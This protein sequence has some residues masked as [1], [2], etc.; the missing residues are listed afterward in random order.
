[1][2]TTKLLNF[3]ISMPSV[4]GVWVKADQPR[5]HL[6]PKPEPLDISHFEHMQ[7]STCMHCSSTASDSQTGDWQV[8]HVHLSVLNL[9][10]L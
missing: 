8:T 2:S 10:T 7:F 9:N 1:M 5:V 4:L 6:K 3:K